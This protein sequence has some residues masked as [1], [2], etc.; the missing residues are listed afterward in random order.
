MAGQIFTTASDK[1]NCF[2]TPSESQPPLT[3]FT[4]AE[5]SIPLSGNILCGS[6]L[7]YISDLTRNRYFFSLSF[8]PTGA[9]RHKCPR[10][11]HNP[12][13]RIPH[14]GTGSE[15]RPQ[16]LA[17]C[18]GSTVTICKPEARQSCQKNLKESE[19]PQASR[20]DSGDSDSTLVDQLERPLRP[21]RIVMPSGRPW[22]WSW[23]ILL[24]GLL[25]LC[26][27][28]FFWWDFYDVV[29]IRKADATRFRSLLDPSFQSRLTGQ[30]SRRLWSLDFF[31]P[32]YFFYIRIIF[33]HY[34]PSTPEPLCWSFLLFASPKASTPVLLS[35]TQ[36]GSGFIL[37]F[38]V[39]SCLPFRLHA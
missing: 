5:P 7:S 34:T 28:P 24:T 11:R 12:I 38:R 4:E 26:R 13:S 29:R 16:R 1:D 23:G 32:F 27:N 19:S 25:N 30:E 17:K 21:A 2:I 37:R 39:R 22:T 35:A 36:H 14:R 18:E 3:G 15:C 10:A 31:F 9:L 6:C 8:V 33:D 20:S